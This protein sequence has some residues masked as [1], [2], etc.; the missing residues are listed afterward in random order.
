MQNSGSRL[1]IITH[2]V[3]HLL[4]GKA[5]ESLRLVAPNFNCRIGFT[6][7]DV[8]PKERRDKDE[9]VISYKLAIT[10]SKTRNNTL[11]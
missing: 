2:R 3:Q 11:H 10:S 8:N 4:G 6:A 9:T 7:R 1:H 5:D